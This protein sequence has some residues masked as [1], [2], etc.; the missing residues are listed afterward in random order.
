MMGTLDPSKGHAFVLD[1][2]ELLW[3]CDVNASLVIVGKQGWMVEALVERLRQHTE[4]NKRLFWFDDISDEQLE[5]A[6][7]SSL[8]LIAASYGGGSGLPLIEAAQHKLPIIARDIPVFREVAGDHAF[9]FNTT[10]PEQ[11]AQSIK[12]WL[13]LYANKEHPMSN[14]MPWL[15]WQ[16]SAQQLLEAIGLAEANTPTSETKH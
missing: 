13:D 8:C 16:Q 6:Y 14:N 3:K 9:Y 7:V 2:F 11:L 10:E 4:L 15:T 5:A 12:Q 1:A